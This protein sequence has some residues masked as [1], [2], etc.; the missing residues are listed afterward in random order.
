MTLKV[1]HFVT[2]FVV[3]WEHYGNDVGG[4]KYSPLADV[5]RSTVSSLRAQWTYRWQ[6]NP[7]GPEAETSYNHQGVPLVLDDG[8]ESGLCDRTED[9][10]W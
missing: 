6:L 1:T 10:L 5:N 7:L 9:L 2:H 8:T 3:Y 4:S